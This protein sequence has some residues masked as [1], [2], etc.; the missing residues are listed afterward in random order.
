MS[1]GVVI[2]VVLAAIAIFT[3]GYLLG[4]QVSIYWARRRCEACIWQKHPGHYR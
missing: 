4:C 2:L 1:A 3:A